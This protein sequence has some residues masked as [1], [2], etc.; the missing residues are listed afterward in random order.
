MYSPMA[1]LIL[2]YFAIEIIISVIAGNRRHYTA[3]GKVCAGTHIRL[4]KT[5]SLNFWP[6]LIL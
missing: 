3:L 6:R 1:A 5:I 2:T 4:L